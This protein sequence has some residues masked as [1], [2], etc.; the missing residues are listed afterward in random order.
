[1]VASLDP[2]K[3]FGADAFGPLR[4][5]VVADDV[6]GDWKP[7]VTLIRLPELDALTCAS[8]TE[9]TCSL[10]GA[11]LYLVETVGRGPGLADP[12]Q[13]PEGFAGHALLVPHPG[14]DGLFV[15]LRDNPAAVHAVAMK[16]VMAEAAQRP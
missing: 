10:S 3:E 14:D 6:E 15:R 5:R 8:L 13:V 4:F 12:V 16:A 1:V 9:P 7:L 11:N 2:A